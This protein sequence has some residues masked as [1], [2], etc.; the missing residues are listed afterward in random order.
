MRKVL[1]TSILVAMIGCTFFVPY[2]RYTPL[3]EYGMERTVKIFVETDSDNPFHPSGVI[4]S[5]AIVSHTGLILTVSHLFEYGHYDVQ[6]QL[7]GS[8]E[9]YTAFLVVKDTETDLALITVVKY[10]QKKFLFARHVSIGEEVLAIGHPLGL[11]WSVTQGIINQEREFGLTYTGYVQTDA[12]V[13]MGNSGGPL[14]NMKGQVVGIN[15]FL[16]TPSMFPVNSGIAVAT[17]IKAIK[18]FLIDR[19][20]LLE[21]K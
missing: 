14:I 8:T 2:G 4:G 7:Y 11:D 19:R 10:L 9:T 1:L 20:K 21:V 18:P 17:S 12:A 13:N 3:A 16:I 6:V 5:G 15:S